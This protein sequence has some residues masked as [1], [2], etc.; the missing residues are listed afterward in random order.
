MSNNLRVISVDSFAHVTLIEL[1]H[2]LFARYSGDVWNG[3]R[4][5]EWLE[6]SSNRVKAR[7]P[8]LRLAGIGIGLGFKGPMRQRKPVALPVRFP[9][10]SNDTEVIT[11]VTTEAVTEATTKF[12]TRVVTQATTKPTIKPTIKPTTIDTT[13]ECGRR[14]NINMD[15]VVPLISIGEET[16]P[17]DW[18]WLAAIFVVTVKYDFQCAGS[19]VTNRHVITGTSIR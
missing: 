1:E 8:Y 16:S 9:I 17:G 7:N 18:P 6:N 14:A 15:I 13:I 4:K 5:K 10:S 3:M 12:T 19:L 2:D 11:K